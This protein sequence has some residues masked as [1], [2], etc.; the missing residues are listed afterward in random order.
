MISLTT[1]RSVRSSWK[2]PLAAPAPHNFYFGE[3]TR[4][5]AAPET[6]PENGPLAPS[7]M[8][9]RPL[10]K[11]HPGLFVRRDRYWGGKHAAGEERAGGG[12]PGTFLPGRGDG[13]RAGEA[14]CA[15][16]GRAGPGPGDG[17]RGD[18]ATVRG[19]RSRGGGPATSPTSPP[20]PPP[21]RACAAPT[22]RA[23][24]LRRRRLPAQRAW[25]R[26]A[27][28]TRA[29]AGRGRG[30]GGAKSWSGPRAPRARPPQGPL[31]DRA[32]GLR[33]GVR[34]PGPCEMPAG[35]RKKCVQCGRSP[36]CRCQEPVDLEPTS[37]ISVIFSGLS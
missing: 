32:S 18:V 20:P 11:G 27:R 2:R 8:P 34:G 30:R 24:R 10:G 5:S 9:S 19:A 3:K 6:R 36:S 14:G 17:G 16:A 35:P 33:R 15:G 12:E 28:K 4:L 21:G 22:P 31:R 37:T 26:A 1:I 7:A 13:A 23:R 25:R 29:G